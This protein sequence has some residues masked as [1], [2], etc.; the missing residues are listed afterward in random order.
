[1]S[2]EVS[3]NHGA[4]NATFDTAGNLR[5]LTDARGIAQTRSHDALNRVSSVTYPAGGENITYTWDAAA[6]CTFGIGRLCAITDN[7]GSTSYAYDARGNRVS[8][9]RTEAGFT[10]TTI[11]G[12]DTADRLATVVAPT[13][14]VLT[15]RRDADG[16]IEQI[17]TEAEG[18]PQ[19]NVVDGVQ[20]DAAGN[21][22]AL[23]QG[24][25]VAQSRSFTEDAR[26][27]QQ[28][29][30]I[31]PGADDPPGGGNPGGTEVDTDAP[32]LPEWGAILMGIALLGAARRRQKRR[33]SNEKQPN[34][35]Q[36]SGSSPAA[37]LHTVLA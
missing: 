17:T 28:T 20:T 5:T 6:G 27:Q 19:L 21:T 11:L 12:H 30:Q 14:Q 34:V 32:T 16:L 31:P 1:V 26:P 10:Y 37:G 13:A 29:Q 4:L 18:N 9:T 33:Q 23:L 35:K 36:A 7:G 24:N 8:Q 2:R 22:T 25:G 3:A 15:L